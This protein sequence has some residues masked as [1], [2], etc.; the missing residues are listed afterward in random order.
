MGK[1]IFM[2]Q[3]LFHEMNNV[4]GLLTFLS[5]PAVIG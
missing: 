2:T 1:V 3:M 4:F 5:L